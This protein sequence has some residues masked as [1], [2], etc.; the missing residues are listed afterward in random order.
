MGLS[1]PDDMSVHD[2]EQWLSNAYCRV[3]GYIGC[4]QGVMWGIEDE[5]EPTYAE[6]GEF[7]IGDDRIRTFYLSDVECEWPVC[8]AINRTARGMGYAIYV[9]RNQRR[10]WRRTF[11]FNC[12]SRHHIGGWGIRRRMPGNMDTPLRRSHQLASDIFDPVYYGPAEAM[13]RIEAGRAVSVAI[14]P[15]ITLVGDGK[16]QFGVYYRR[17]MVG[18]IRDGVFTAAIEGFTKRRVV[19]ALQGVLK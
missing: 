17:D 10:Q 3:G 9:Q 5:D 6:Q 15:Q 12:V 13:L 14:S 2:V 4:L 8:G 11:N 7:D 1:L 18:G 16:G 19:S